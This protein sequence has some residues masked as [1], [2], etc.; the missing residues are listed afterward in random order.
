MSVVRLKDGT[1]VFA[2]VARGKTLTEHDK[3]VLEEYAQ[4][5]RERA[6]KEQRKRNARLLPG[7]RA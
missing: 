7:G 5:C 2:C 3:A 4:F 1:K 6:A